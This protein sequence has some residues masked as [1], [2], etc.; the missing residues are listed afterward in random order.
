MPVEEDDDDWG[1]DY[2][3]EISDEDD[4][5]KAANLSSE[6]VNYNLGQHQDLKQHETI[7]VSYSLQPV[8]YQNLK[9][10]NPFLKN[11]TNI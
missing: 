6:R 11:R 2:T 7:A 9:A 10:R 4:I 3:E 1:Q 5:T 8:K